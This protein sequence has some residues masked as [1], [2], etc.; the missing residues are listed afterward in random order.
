MPDMEVAIGV[1]P[2][3]GDVDVFRHGRRSAFGLSQRDNAVMIRQMG[4]CGQCGDE[5]NNQGSSS[6]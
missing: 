6:K 5:S 3:D 1:G 2:G 4:G